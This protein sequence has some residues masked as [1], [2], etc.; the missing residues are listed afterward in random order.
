M[1]VVHKMRKL[2]WRPK[3]VMLL[4]DYR[5]NYF[6]LQLCLFKLREGDLNEEEARS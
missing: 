4:N 1:W 3:E 6:F 2:G 5:V